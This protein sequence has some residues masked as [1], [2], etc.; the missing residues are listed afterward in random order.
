MRLLHTSDWHLGQTLYDFDR[1]YE[2]ERFLNWL[3]D[4][5]TRTEPDALLIAGDIFDNA[6]PSAKAQHQ[7]YRF[8]ASARMRAPKLNIVV[9]AGNHDSPVRL[10]ATSPFL[11]MFDAVVIG[12]A[13]RAPDQSIDV[14]RMVV[15]LTNGDGQVGAWCVALPFLR[16][17]DVPRVEDADDAYLAGVEALY[18][19]AFEIARA[20]RTPEQAIVA[21]GHCHMVDGQT[22]AQSERRIV[23]GGAEALPVRMFDDTVAYAAL[24]HLHL[25][26][27]VGGRASIRYSGS[28]LP[29]S[30]TE[31]NYPHQ[32]VCVDLDGDAPARIESIRV[33]RSVDLI[34]IP[35]R[36][37]PLDDVIQELEQLEM[38]PAKG[39]PPEALPYL[40]VRVRL[41]AP[42][43]GLRAR[44]DAALEGKAVRLARID[45]ASSAS[46]GDDSTAPI[47]I[48]D[49]DRLAPEDVFAKLCAQRIGPDA[50][51]RD[52]L[53]AAL[54]A[55]F[56]ELVHDLP[57]EPSA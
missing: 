4:E 45:P 25:A 8:L 2:H 9:T 54:Q 18:E 12:Q 39:S 29:M 57:E 21:M 42:E 13:H 31:I 27:S 35:Q 41:D 28:P 30:F 1:S 15:P 16:P 52:A 26:Q 43:P 3:L 37:A 47:S 36:H 34:R 56:H 23:V 49:L 24:G 50:P 19:Q 17:S 11:E 53:L 14:E 33:P 7:F 55:A 10:E 22:S 44:I 48:S 20:K 38:A 32:I 46:A 5:I 40:E 6:N 51:E